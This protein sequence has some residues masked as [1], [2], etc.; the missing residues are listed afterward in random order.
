LGYVPSEPHFVLELESERWLRISV[1]PEDEDVDTMLLMRGRTG[2]VC[3]DNASRHTFNPEIMTRLEPGRYRVFVGTAEEG[4]EGRFNLHVADLAESELPEVKV[5][6]T[7]SMMGRSGGSFEATEI[8]ESCVGAISSR[9]NHVILVSESQYLAISA[10]SASDLTLV[11]V[12]EDGVRCN[13]D[14]HRSLNPTVVD[15]F[16]EGPISIYVGSHNP[17]VRAYYTLEVEP[18]QPGGFF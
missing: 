16:R 1:E 5:G 3:N 2:P 10:V 9:P 7:L 11:V 13:D 6:D 14:G 17:D 15:W 4:V 18:G 12:G 8:G